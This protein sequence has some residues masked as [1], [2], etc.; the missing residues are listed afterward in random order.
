MMNSAVFRK[1]M[2][3]GR[4]HR[5]TKLIATKERRNYCGHNET[6][7]F[8]GNLLATQME[9]TQIRINRPV[10]LGL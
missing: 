10:Y 2:V 3:N 8:S 4:R 6:K 7:K 5:D 9:R 1:T